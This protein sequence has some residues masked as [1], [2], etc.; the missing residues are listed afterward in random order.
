MKDSPG[1]RPR[2]VSRNGFDRPRSVW[3]LAQ[4]QSWRLYAP[5]FVVLLCASGCSRSVSNHHGL[6]VSAEHLPRLSYAPLLDIMRL[7]GFGGG[8]SYSTR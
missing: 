6:A 3:L 8:A 7:G 5:C 2:H 1:G 4:R